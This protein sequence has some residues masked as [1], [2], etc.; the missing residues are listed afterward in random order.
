MTLSWD[1]EDAERLAGQLSPPASPQEAERVLRRI[2]KGFAHELWREQHESQPT[3]Q[4]RQELEA[5]RKALDGLSRRATDVLCNAL[6][7]GPFLPHPYH[8]AQ[9]VISPCQS[10]VPAAQF[11]GPVMLRMMRLAIERAAEDLP[12]RR[13]GHPGKVSDATRRAIKVLCLLY[14]SCHRVPPPTY[15]FGVDDIRN[16]APFEFAME[17]LRAWHAPAIAEDEQPAVVRSL[18]NYSGRNQ[19]E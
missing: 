19:T 10:D 17:C 16:S 2:Y 18:H 3:K 8:E 14:C 5:L 13:P 1:Y 11:S 7:E 15:Y 4:V 12:H 9:L 6:D